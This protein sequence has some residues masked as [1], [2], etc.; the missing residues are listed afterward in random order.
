MANGLGIDS[1]HLG[2]LMIVNLG[3]GY[4]TPPMGLNLIV[5]M[6][7]FKAD[8]MTV[9]RAMLPFIGLM[10]LALAVI[11]LIPEISTFLL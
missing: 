11:A 4:L 6:G 2:I 8:F 7:A 5:A 9:T 10:L 3:I 1:V